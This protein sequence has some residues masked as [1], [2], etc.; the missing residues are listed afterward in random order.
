MAKALHAVCD[1]CP[2]QHHQLVKSWGPKDA[3]WV[4][5]GEGPGWTE[6]A[7]GRPF[8]G[9]SGKYL[10]RL[11]RAE[12]ID[13]D[14]V[15]YTN[16]TLCHPGQNKDAT[17][18]AAAA[19]CKTRLDWLINNVLDPEANILALGAVAQRALGARIDVWQ[20]RVLGGIHPAY[21]LRDPD[22]HVFLAQTIKKFAKGRLQADPLPDYWVDVEGIDRWQFD[23][24]RYVV[25]VETRPDGTV[26][27]V[28]LGRLWKNYCIVHIISE[29]E[30]SCPS[31][32]D[33]LNYVWHPQAKAAL[34]GHNIKYDM[35]ALNRCFGTP[36]A[37]AGDTMV[38]I[39]V[40]VPGWYRGLK[41]LAGYY[42]DAPDYE[43]RFK[44]F[45]TGGDYSSA[46]D[47]EVSHYLAQDVFYTGCLSYEVEEELLGVARYDKPYLRFEMPLSNTLTEMEARGVAVDINGLAAI[48]A[49]LVPVVEAHRQQIIDLSGGVVK[50]PASPVQ[51]S[52]FLWG[53]LQP[54]AHG[55]KKLAATSTD[56][57]V[58]IDLRDRRGFDHPF[59]AAILAFRR[60]YKLLTSYI[61]NLTQFFRA[62]DR[63]QLR[64]HPSYNQCDVR[65]G[66]MSARRPAIQTIV[67]EDKQ[68]DA[69]Q[70]W[71]KRIKSIYT[72]PQYANED[73]VLVGVDGEQWEMRVAGVWSQDPWLLK[74]FSAGVSIHNMAC[75]MIWS[76]GWDNAMKTREKNVMFGLLYGGQL[77]VLIAE[78]GL[79]PDSVAAIS[80][81]FTQTVGRLL[82]WR[83]EMYE[84]AATQG[85]IISPHFNRLYDFREQLRLGKHHLEKIAV[86]WPVQGTAS[87]ITMEAACI[88][89]PQLHKHNASLIIAQHDELVAE[90]PASAAEEVLAIITASFEVAGRAFYPDIPWIAKGNIGRKWGELK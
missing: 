26:F 78:S 41:D 80:D 38:G 31:F 5:V 40:A 75:D 2:Y 24:P 39:N 44:Q 33:W 66:R 72:A 86:N 37:H 10:R 67:K 69:D 71:G 45:V 17:L 57:S 65:T 6:V 1:F 76:G 61:D 63:G 43:A 60:S 84:T 62:D 14:G 16:A 34:W 18:E 82:E 22:Q 30:L 56:E 49:D 25:D 36:L 83:A 11:L 3:Q 28:G 51:V 54:P 55:V 48:R 19:A 15:F 21:A 32:Q 88:A 12:G 68:K 79:P 20:G 50:N 53:V 90:A 77:E 87:Q 70:E 64:V 13:P 89:Q 8:V 7:Q 46:P 27:K 35:L 47:H 59:L 4:V 52:K 29:P 85:C 42:F 74:A 23:A 9:E 81:F 58:L 73:W